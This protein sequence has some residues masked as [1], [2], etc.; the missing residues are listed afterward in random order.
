VFNSRIAT[1]ISIPT[2]LLMG[3]LMLVDPS[4]ATIFL[5]LVLGLA[6]SRKIDNIAFQIGIFMIILIPVIFHQIVSIEWLPFG[7]L[8]LAAMADEYGNDWSDRRQMEHHVNTAMKRRT[9][10]TTINQLGQI[11]FDHRP[12]M[13][14]TVLIL[15]VTNFFPLIYFLA[16]LA[17]DW[18][19][20]IVE[21][22]SFK[23]KTYHLT[24]PIPQKK[25]NNILE[26][27]RGLM[28]LD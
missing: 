4:S 17:F 10:T 21:T 5:A 27:K 22:I 9:K 12:I 14:V 1:I 18:T 25:L 15:T 2:A 20:K 16:F 23:Q 26:N 7:I 6:V 19:Y 11:L 24:E 3:A 13:K 8:V 28:L